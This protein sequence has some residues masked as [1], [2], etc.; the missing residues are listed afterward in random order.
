[1]LGLDIIAARLE[2]G[3]EFAQ[4]LRCSLQIVASNRL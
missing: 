4:I 3:P 2:T 1:M